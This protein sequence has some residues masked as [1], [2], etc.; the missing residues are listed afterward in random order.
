MI[1]VTGIP[2]QMPLREKT[3]LEIREE[4]ESFSYKTKPL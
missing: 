3:L 4:V 1:T 2:V